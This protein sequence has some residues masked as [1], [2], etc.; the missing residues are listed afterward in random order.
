MFHFSAEYRIPLYSVVQPGSYRRQEVFR[1]IL[2]TDAGILDPEPWRL[3]TDELHR[4]YST[5]IVVQGAEIGRHY[6]LR[7]STIQLG[8]SADCDIR[9]L[10]DQ[11]SRSHAKIDRTWDPENGALEDYAFK[12]IG[13]WRK[14]RPSFR[15]DN[16]ATTAAVN[17]LLVE[18]GVSPTRLVVEEEDLEQYFL[19]LVGMDG[20]SGNE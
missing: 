16:D 3:D 15:L 4:R 14:Q 12:Y 17:R 8:R 18:T 6:L 11:A 1:A 2:F 20:G 5:L 13:S 10:D 7:E 9:L 19:R